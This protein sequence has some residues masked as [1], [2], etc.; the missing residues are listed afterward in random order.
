MEAAKHEPVPVIAVA[1]PPQF[2][3]IEKSYDLS[4]YKD[5]DIV[6]GENGIYA[7]GKK[8]GSGAFGIV[9]RATNIK[10]KQTVAIKIIGIDDCNEREI[11]IM[12]VV[13]NLYC[14]S[15]IDCLETDESFY[16]VMEFCSQGDLFDAIEADIL[17]EP[18][19]QKAAYD[20][21]KGLQ[22]LHRSGI[23][24]RDIK[25]E[26]ILHYVG[27]DEKNNLVDNWKVADFGIATF[28]TEGKMIV[29]S[30][31]TTQYKAPEMF[32]PAKYTKAVDL[33]AVG[34]TIY[35]C[36]TGRFVWAG[37][38]DDEVLDSIQSYRIDYDNE[39]S[40]TAFS[41]ILR[42]LDLNPETRMTIEEAFSHQW[43]TRHHKQ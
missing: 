2:V 43:L 7:L 15:F 41:I 3:A 11:Q 19:V 36:L 10:N 12:R 35:V 34:I 21:L 29:G 25:P 22:Y 28:F 1:P 17:D 4:P 9:K 33:W 8:L 31:G 6:E 30:T 32:P 39:F 27:V 38:A 16:I 5:M 23:C 40:S 26:N 18:R 14:V 37:E 13:K 24:H 20:T 42:L